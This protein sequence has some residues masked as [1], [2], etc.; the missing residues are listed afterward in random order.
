MHSNPVKGYRMSEESL[1]ETFGSVAQ[2]FPPA[3]LL[4]KVFWA[5][6]LAQVWELIEEP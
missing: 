4:F 6:T 2:S 1:G 5:S 3:S